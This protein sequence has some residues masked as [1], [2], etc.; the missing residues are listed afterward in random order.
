MLEHEKSDIEEENFSL[1]CVHD[2]QKDE[3]KSL[4]RTKKPQKSAAIFQK[5]LERS[6]SL[7][8][9]LQNHE[10]RILIFLLRKLSLV[11]LSSINRMI[12]PLSLRLISMDIAEC[13]QPITQPSSWCLA[14][15]HRTGR[16]YLRFGL[17][18]TTG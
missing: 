1:H 9:N 12:G 13:Q 10:K 18:G 7:L 2:G 5:H 14:S 4:R 17:N 8:N 15:Y 6:T 3:R 16:R 11:L